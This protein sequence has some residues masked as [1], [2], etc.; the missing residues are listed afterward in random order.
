MDVA[1]GA[2]RHLLERAALRADEPAHD[3]HG[4]EH[5]VPRHPR[6]HLEAKVVEVAEGVKVVEV[7]EGVKV[8]VEEEVKVVEVVVEVVEVEE[9]PA[10]R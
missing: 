8:E 1:A 2:D 9:A 6:R 10:A 4:D 3:G 5:V 7:V